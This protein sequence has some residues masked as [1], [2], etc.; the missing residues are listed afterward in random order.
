MVTITMVTVIFLR[1]FSNAAAM[2]DARYLMLAK[3]G[4]HS[5]VTR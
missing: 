5:K 3:G 1:V 4:C 2:P